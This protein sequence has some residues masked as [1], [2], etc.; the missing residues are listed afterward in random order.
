VI[1]FALC[2]SR[3]S[4]RVDGR[5]SVRP[6]L[7]VASRGK[8]EEP[9]GDRL[10]RPGASGQLRAHAD[11]TQLGHGAGRPPMTHGFLPEP[12]RREVVMLMLRN[13]QRHQDVDVQQT[14]HVAD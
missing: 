6:E 2:A 4:A 7:V 9:I 11:H 8:Q 12:L 13:E 10:R 1:C 3:T 14:D 5:H